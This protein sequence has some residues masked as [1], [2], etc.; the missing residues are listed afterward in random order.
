[1]KVCKICSTTE[2]EKRIYV[3]KKFNK[4]LCSTCYHK[5]YMREKYGIKDRS[6]F[7]KNEIVVHDTYAEILLYDRNHKEKARAKIDLQDIKNVSKFKWYLTASG[8]VYSKGGIKLHTL[9]MGECL[10]DHK[11]RDKLNNQRANLRSCTPQEN[12]QNLPKRCDN[13]SGVTGV[14]FHKETKKWRAYINIDGKQL[15]L[16]LHQDK[17]KAIEARLQAE[18]KYFKEFA[19]QRHLYEEYGL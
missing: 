6:K 13:S 14:N 3:S 15:Y 11:D 5:K 2:A 16:G 10:W 9:V 19:P 8:Y 18:Q 1:M 12:N 7:D 17:H 4:I